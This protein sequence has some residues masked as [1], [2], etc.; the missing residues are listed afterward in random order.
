MNNSF[1]MQTYL[2]FAA[3]IEADLWINA[4]MEVYLATDQEL[5]A[6]LV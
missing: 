3:E 2:S 1:E 5:E 4:I 6:L